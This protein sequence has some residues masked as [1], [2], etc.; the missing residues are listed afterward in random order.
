M[1]NVFKIQ[2]ANFEHI[3]QNGDSFAQL[4]KKN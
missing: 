4:N 3:Y 1:L 2:S